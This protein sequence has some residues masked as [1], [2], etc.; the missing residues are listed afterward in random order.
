MPYSKGSSSEKSLAEAARRATKKRITDEEW[1][2]HK[3]SIARLYI[4][5]GKDVREVRDTMKREFGFEAQWVLPAFLPISR[6][7]VWDNTIA[8]RRIS[9]SSRS[10]AWLRMYL[11]KRVFS[12]WESE[13][14]DEQL[15][16]TP[17]SIVGEG[18]K[19]FFSLYRTTKL[20]E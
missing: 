20:I 18:Q 16:K 9:G 17:S 3:E 12:W 8:R 7:N 13:S 14:S 10:G 19:A 6:G 15:A 5:E 2:L 11:R 1:L 4:D